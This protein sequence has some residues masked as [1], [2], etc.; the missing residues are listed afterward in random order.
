MRWGYQPIQPKV[1]K[2]HNPLA[3]LMKQNKQFVWR[4]TYKCILSCL[5]DTKVQDLQD[6]D[7]LFNK[8]EISCDLFSK[9][10]VLYL[11]A[12]FVYVIKSFVERR[13]SN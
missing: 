10:I 6:L 2:I 11:A 1:S 3:H 13:M 12:I 8:L 4:L 9:G 5:K 7:Y